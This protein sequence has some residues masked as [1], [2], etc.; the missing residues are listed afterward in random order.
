VPPEL[1]PHSVWFD[2]RFREVLGHF[3]GKTYRQDPLDPDHDEALSLR[4]SRNRYRDAL[5]LIRPELETPGGRSFLDVG[6]GHLA[7][8]A[9]PRFPGRTFA[10]DLSGLYAEEARALGVETRRWDVTR[11]DCP[12]PERSQD[13][14]AFTEVIEHLPPPPFPYLQRVVRLLKPGGI[15]LFSCPNMAAFMKRVKFFFLGRSPIKL[16]SARYE[17][18]G[19]PEHIREYTY[20]EALRILALTGLSVER[21]RTGDYGF[22]FWREVTTRLHGVLPS[23]G[24]TILVRARLPG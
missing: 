15:L 22:G 4:R 8:F 3:E 9:A 6:G 14:V 23:L 10:A 24:R 5:A 20:A 1:P 12:F 21:V 16:G 11:D 13:I 18:S 17:A 7:W 2:A 19:Y